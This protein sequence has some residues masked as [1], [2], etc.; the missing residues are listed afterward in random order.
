MK[1]KEYLVHSTKIDKFLWYTY[2]YKERRV[3]KLYKS[4]NT[5]IDISF[6]GRLCH[7]YN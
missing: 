1:S 2:V 5:R 3:I 4:W 7:N 6:G